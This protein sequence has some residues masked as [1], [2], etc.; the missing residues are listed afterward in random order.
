M[1]NTGA[2]TIQQ[3]LGVQ[4]SAANTF[5]I[6]TLVITMMLSMA[7]HAKPEPMTI[8]KRISIQRVLPDADDGFGY[9]LEFLVAAPIEAV[10]HFKTDFNLKGASLRGRYLWYGGMK[11]TLTKVAKWEQKPA[12]ESRRNYLAALG[13][14]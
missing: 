12:S 10:W 9:V 14:E 6:A 11:S 5:F 4:S 2:H 8:D 7:A 13:T 3:Q 1:K